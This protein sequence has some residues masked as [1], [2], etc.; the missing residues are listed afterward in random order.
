MSDWWNSK[1]ANAV[2]IFIS[3]LGY[4][5]QKMT[6]TIQMGVQSYWRYCMSICSDICGRYYQMSSIRPRC[7]GVKVSHPWRLAI[8]LA[9]LGISIPDRQLA[10]THDFSN[11]CGTLPTMWYQINSMLVSDWC[12]TSE[13][14]SVISI[15]FASSTP[16]WNHCISMFIYGISLGEEMS[17]TVGFKCWW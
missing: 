5:M 1:N 2:L 4:T 12:P 14:I 17:E 13:G 7:W 15:W 8:L 10:F 11:L 3:A 6:S 16:H 9:W